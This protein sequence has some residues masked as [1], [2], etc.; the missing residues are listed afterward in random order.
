LPR[1]YRIPD[2]GLPYT[3]KRKGKMPEC[4]SKTSHDKGSRRSAGTIAIFGTF[5]PAVDP[6]IVARRQV[7]APEWHASL[8]H[9]RRQRS[10]CAPPSG[11]KVLVTE[12]EVGPNGS[13]S[14][15]ATKESTIHSA[16]PIGSGDDVARTSTVDTEG[17]A[18]IQSSLAD[19]TRKVSPSEGDTTGNASGSTAAIGGGTEV[20]ATI[21]GTEVGAETGGTKGLVTGATEVGAET[22]GMKTTVAT[23]KGG[24]G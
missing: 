4:V 24:V 9:G 2:A 6:T 12:S 22:G 17:H 19:P 3:S 23:V 11:G 8:A 13:R 5:T 15:G 20:G 18:A 7:E 14:G 10:L 21:G 1:G 16:A